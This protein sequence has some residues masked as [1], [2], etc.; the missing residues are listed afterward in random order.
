METEDS[1]ERSHDGGTSALLTPQRSHDHERAQ[2]PGALR[3]QLLGEGDAPHNAHFIFKGQRHA[4]AVF[5]SVNRD[6]LNSI[7]QQLPL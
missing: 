2:A 3:I 4:L 5:P 6:G 7:T 1:G